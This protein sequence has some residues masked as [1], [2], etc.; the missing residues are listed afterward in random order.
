M[1]TSWSQVVRKTAAFRLHG[2]CIQ[3]WTAKHND[4]GTI[5]IKD[6]EH[7]PQKTITQWFRDEGGTVEAV[8]QRVPGRADVT[9][10]RAK[11]VY[12]V[13]DTLSDSRSEERRVGKGC[14]STC[15]SR[16]SPEP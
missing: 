10:P 15:R 8:V 11:I 2:F 7:R 16:R 1:T 13:D 5:G 14:V 12:A 9:L 4:D 3:E 6:I